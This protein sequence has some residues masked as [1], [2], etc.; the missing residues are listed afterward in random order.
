MTALGLV[1]AFRS[2]G[3]PGVHGAC[4]F[5]PAVVWLLSKLVLLNR[6]AC[7][8]LTSWNDKDSVWLSSPI[9]VSFGRS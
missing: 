1:A 9:P 2:Q 3:A 6:A 5:G 4:A 7:G 8:S